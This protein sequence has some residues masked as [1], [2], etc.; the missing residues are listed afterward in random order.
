M[1]KDRPY[2]LWGVGLPCRQTAWCVLQTCLQLPLPPFSDSLCI[3][4]AVSQEKFKAPTHDFTELSPGPALVGHLLDGSEDAQLPASV[5][6]P[7]LWSLNFKGF[8]QR[9]ITGG[10]LRKGWQN[11]PVT[12]PLTVGGK[13]PRGWW[14]EGSFR[15]S[16]TLTDFCKNWVLEYHL[17]LYLCECVLG[18]GLTL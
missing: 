12:R 9:R 5:G 15:P 14:I 7:H 11:H 8:H 18:L 10:S 3:L 6:D 13:P 17:Q 1:L 2:S 4:R 16:S